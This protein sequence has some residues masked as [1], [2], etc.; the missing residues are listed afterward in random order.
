MASTADL[1][2]TVRRAG[3]GART[4]HPD[5]QP[6]PGIGADV[7]GNKVTVPNQPLHSDPNHAHGAASK[8][9][10]SSITCHLYDFFT[11][12]LLTNAY[13]QSYLREA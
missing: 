11:N 3:A 12:D 9:A 5:P 10:D 8:T 7:P 2:T 4:L 6:H 13:E 1:S